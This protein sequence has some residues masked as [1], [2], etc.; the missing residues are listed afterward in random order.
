MR[1]KLYGESS[2][3]ELLHGLLTARDVARRNNEEA[4]FANEEG[5]NKKATPH[6]YQL[7]QLVLLDEHSFLQRNAKLA[8]KWSGPHRIVPLKKD[9]KV[10]L[11]LR[12]G[13]NLITHVNRLKPYH[14]PVGE[15]SGEFKE[16]PLRNLTN[17][18]DE[19]DITPTPKPKNDTPKMFTDEMKIET[20]DNKP[21]PF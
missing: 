12:S 16:R 21:L 19:E 20:R 5:H 3:D 14:V 10:E 6:S 8:P 15:S 1:R 18:D 11:K 17:I 7:G 13:R 4:S 9:N 2:T